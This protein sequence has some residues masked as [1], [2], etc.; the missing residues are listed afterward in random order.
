MVMF[1]KYFTIAR[2]LLHTLFEDGIGANFAKCKL[3]NAIYLYT[4]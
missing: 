2:N 1:G 3:E 4:G